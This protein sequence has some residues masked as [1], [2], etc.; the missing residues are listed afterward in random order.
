MAD[1][2]KPIKLVEKKKVVTVMDVLRT[3]NGSLHDEV[4]K[5]MKKKQ[6]EKT[7]K[8]KKPE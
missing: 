4:R 3:K 1:E 2:R 6:P 5:S 7:A 8:E